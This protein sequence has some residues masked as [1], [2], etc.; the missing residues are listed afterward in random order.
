[1]TT[2]TAEQLAE[3]FFDKWYCENGLPA[4]I[5]SDR[6]KLFMS[7]FWKVLHKLTNV[8][9]KAS[10]AYHPETDGASERSNK[11]VIQAL[12]YHVDDNQSG[13]VRALPRIRFAIMNT[14]NKS[15]GFTPFQLR[16]GCSPRILPPFIPSEVEK[17]LDTNTE[18]SENAARQVASRIHFD[19]LEAQD[20]LLR[21]KIS[22]AAQANKT[23]L[24]TFPFKVGQRVRLSTE[25]RRREFKAA[26]ERRVAKFMP[27]FGGPWKITA[28]NVDSSTVTLDLPNS[29]NF[30]PVFH[31]S[32]LIP[33]IE[34][35][36]ELFPGR[37]VHK[38][39]PMR[40][41]N[42]EEH[43]IERIIRSRRR[44]RGRQ[45]LVR[46]QGEGPEGDIWLPRS[47]LNECE[48]LDVWLAENPDD[49]I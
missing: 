24:L 36:D 49:S 35:E 38:P 1:V 21:A 44:G 17:P 33:Y 18:P 47:E 45:F 19:F 46:W 40:I 37:A 15:T 7:K 31:T 14:I 26:G 4:D 3:I 13:W 34:N 30:H 9:I 10:T 42:F 12:R 41:D 27:R 25:N 6:D 32:E 2:I 43:F 22:Q 23:R 48:A 16:F 39:K 5:I 8:K 29:A 11:T 28:I 20:N